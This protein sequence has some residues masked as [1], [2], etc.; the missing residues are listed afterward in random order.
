M[1]IYSDKIDLIRNSRLVYSLDTVM[2]CN[3]GLLQNP[4]GCY[5]DCYSLKN[6]RLYGYDYSKIVLRKFYSEYHRRQIIARINS[7]ESDFIRI[8]QSGDPSEDWRHTFEILDKIK[9]CNKEIVIIT[10][11]WHK[12]TNT[13]L[14]ALAGLNVCFNTSVSAMD[15]E[16][17]I[18][19]SLCEYNRLKSVCKSVLRV[20]TSKFN[21]ENEQGKRLSLIQDDILNQNDVIETIFRPSVTND[22]VLKGIIMTE[23]AEFLTGKVLASVRDQSTYFGDCVRCHEQCGLNVTIKERQYPIKPGISKKL[24]LWTQ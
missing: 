22:L 2:G 5:G 20:I 14:N 17:L 3:S 9:H 11:H 7:V 24:N 19:K 1:K 16:R 4:N 13:Q 18:S 23:K 21:L 15:N 10:R 8:G 12:M 6:A